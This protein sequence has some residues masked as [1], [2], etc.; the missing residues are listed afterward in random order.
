MVP[1]AF[2]NP[3]PARAASPERGWTN[4]AKP[5]GTAIAMPVGSTARSPGA[6]VM[7]SAVTMS[8]PAS[9]GNADAGSGTSGSRR[10]PSTSGPA[11]P[12]ASTMSAATLDALTPGTEGASADGATESAPPSYRERLYTPWWWYLVAI[13]IAGV[14]AAEFHVAGIGL[15]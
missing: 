13:G 9:P 1:G 8:A 15:T 12:A 5:S 10:C 14:L 7:S 3:S 2:T 11:P 6:R 4:A